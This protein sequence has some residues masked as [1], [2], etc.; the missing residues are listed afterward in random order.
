MLLVNRKLYL[1]FVAVEPIEYTNVAWLKKNYFHISVF[2][3][4]SHQ[5][6]CSLTFTFSSFGFFMVFNTTSNNISA[7]S[8]WS[9]LL[10]EEPG[11]P[12]ENH[13]LVGSQ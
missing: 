7:I 11:V 10:V 13:R 4:F 1:E 6:P 2:F 8:W 5:L 9:I 3:T 12:G